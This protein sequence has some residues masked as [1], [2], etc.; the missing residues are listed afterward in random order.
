MRN[1][2]ITT[3]RLSFSACL[4]TWGQAAAAG[5]R[6]AW[7]PYLS[8]LSFLKPSA[9][10]GRVLGT[11]CQVPALDGST[12]L[13]VTLSTV[14]LCPNVR[15]RLKFKAEVLEIKQGLLLVTVVELISQSTL[16]SVLAWPK[17]RSKLWQ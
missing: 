13:K 16:L 14:I 9:P 8:H 15:Q 11:P 2:V 17:L 10:L 6:F 4:G 12:V 7:R 5:R 1:K 3:P